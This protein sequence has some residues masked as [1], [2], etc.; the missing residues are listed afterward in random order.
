[1]ST[2][3]VAHMLD[4][5]SVATV[6]DSVRQA[7]ESHLC[8][9]GYCPVAETSPTAAIRSPVNQNYDFPAVMQEVLGRESATCE[10]CQ[11]RVGAAGGGDLRGREWFVIRRLVEN[12]FTVENTVLLCNS[13]ANRERADWTA[14]V[15]RKRARDRSHPPSLWV[16][17]KYWLTQPTATTTLLRRLATV[18]G[19]LVALFLMVIAG[20]VLVSASV[21]DSLAW[22]ELLGGL[23]RLGGSLSHILLDTSWVVATVLSLGYGA[24]AAER[25]AHDP[26]GPPQTTRPPWIGLAISGGLALG[27]ACGL[28]IVTASQMVSPLGTAL[29]YG[30]WLLGAGGV[31]WFLDRTL[32]TDRA[33]HVW[34][35]PRLPWLLAGRLAAVPGLVAL[36]VGVPFPQVF[37]AATP[38]LLT[39]LPGA[40]ALTYVGRRLPYDPTARDAL[41]E[42]IPESVLTVLQSGSDR[43]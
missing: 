35:P 23:T 19:A 27:A 10:A 2:R 28:L 6:R 34:Y 14:A 17:L 7:V 21:G 42:A 43:E 25:V 37:I 40:I 30:L 31:S 20:A 15:R 38:E 32:R 5:P 9:E 16:L 11:K 36:F 29:F 26:R 13:C 22:V 33:D 12:V 39:V 18:S 41:L 3:G 24:H 4:V 8:P 1:M